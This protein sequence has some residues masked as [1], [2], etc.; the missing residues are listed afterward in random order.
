MRKESQQVEF[1]LSIDM[2]GCLYMMP[3]NTWISFDSTVLVFV[4]RSVLVIFM[5]LIL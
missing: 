1:Y 5:Y 2:T 4:L 3:E